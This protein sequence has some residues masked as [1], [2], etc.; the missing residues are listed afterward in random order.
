MVLSLQL[1]IA[2][3]SPFWDGEAIPP[4]GNLVNKE[5]QTR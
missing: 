2:K 3:P 1:V 5:T 4:L